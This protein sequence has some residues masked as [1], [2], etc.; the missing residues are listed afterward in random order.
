LRPKSPY[1]YLAV[2]NKEVA[3]EVIDACN[4]K[5]W[6]YNVDLGI[7]EIAPEVDD[8]IFENFR[9]IKRAANLAA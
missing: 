4:I 5:A 2:A 6:F 9:Q 1:G 7:V 8:D 3:I